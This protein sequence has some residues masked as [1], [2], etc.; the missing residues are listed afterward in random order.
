MQRG[1]GRFRSQARQSGFVIVASCHPRIH[2]W[3]V[4]LPHYLY[5]PFDLDLQS[6]I[7][8]TKVGR[9]KPVDDIPHQVAHFVVADLRDLGPMDAVAVS[10][11]YGHIAPVAGPGNRRLACR[12]GLEVRGAWCERRASPFLASLA[13]MRFSASLF[14]SE[15]YCLAQRRARRL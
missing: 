9:L 14:M 8:S 11:D 7:V 5:P 4:P 15:A 10:I 3:L 13:A 2:L 6:R 12:D 1:K